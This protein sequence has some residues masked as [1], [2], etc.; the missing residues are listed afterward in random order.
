MLTKMLTY[1]YPKKTPKKPQKN[2]KKKIFV[3][4]VT[5]NAVIKNIIIYIYPL[6]NINGSKMVI[7]W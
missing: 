6:E 3:K 2:P 4:L 7:K 1:A 5:L